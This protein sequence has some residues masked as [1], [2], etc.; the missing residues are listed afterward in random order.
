MVRFTVRLVLLYS[1]VLPFSVSNVDGQDVFQLFPQQAPMDYVDILKS[2]K[3]YQL[4][5][6]EFREA[7]LTIARFATANNGLNESMLRVQPGFKYLKDEPRDSG[8]IVEMGNV[9]GSR[10]MYHFDRRL[11]SLYRVE[12]LSANVRN[13]DIWFTRDQKL[14]AQTLGLGIVP[15]AD[16]NATWYVYFHKDV[17]QPRMAFLF[18][19]RKDPGVGRFTFF[20]W[21]S[22]GNK[23]VELPLPQARH[24]F[25]A[26]DLV[27]GQLTTKQ[28]DA[29]KIPLKERAS[30]SKG[31]R[32][33]DKLIQKTL[34]AVARDLESYGDLA[35]DSLLEVSSGKTV[36]R[37]ELEQSVLYK[38]RGKRRSE[39]SVEYDRDSGQLKRIERE[40]YSGAYSTY[41]GRIHVIGGYLRVGSFRPAAGN[42]LA[43][44]YPGRLGPRLILVG[45]DRETGLCLDAAEVHVWNRNGDILAT[46]PV[47]PETPIAAVLDGIEERLTGQQREEIDWQGAA[48]E[49]DTLQ[50]RF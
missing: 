25:D 39:I 19:N 16:G 11:K 43:S 44:V 23:V 17:N 18:P 28:F 48:V 13:I 40:G 35:P 8:P 24:A 41:Q 38:I 9:D 47:E 20:G 26:K 33:A 10:T 34:L 15:W 36:E 27:L 21:D 3:A 50:G 30:V 46:A 49:S 31:Y 5:D 1:I 37:I 32:S 2:G 42:I 4:A 22:A 6:E 7:L 45:V 12:N 29:L 14:P